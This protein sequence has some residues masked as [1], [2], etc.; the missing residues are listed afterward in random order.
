MKPLLNH[1][2]TRFPKDSIG[3]MLADLIISMEMNFPGTL[4]FT[5]SSILELTRIAPADDVSILMP[6]ESAIFI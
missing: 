2:W 6:A 3:Y 1:V 5:R 4:L